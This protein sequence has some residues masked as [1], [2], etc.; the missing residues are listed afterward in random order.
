VLIGIKS[1]FH[2]GVQDI[3]DCKFCTWIRKRVCTDCDAK[4]NAFWDKSSDWEY[5]ETGYFELRDEESDA[6]RDLLDRADGPLRDNPETARAIYLDLAQGGSPTAMFHVGLCSANGSSVE[7]DDW[8]AMEWYRAGT[9]AGSWTAAMA[10]A[11]LL[12]Q[13][14]DFESCD[15]VLDDA[16][17]KGVVTAYYRM[18]RYKYGRAPNRR[19]AREIRSLLDYAI[20]NEHPGA[21]MFL[22][23]L[24]TRG[25]FGL[26]NIIGGIRL[27]V[28]CMNRYESEFSDTSDIDPTPAAL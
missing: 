21:E 4:I 9:I 15:E 24:M 26:R 5:W 10:Y 28:N 27:G 16:I 19:T 22:S 12:N 23:E 2:R 13:H 6:N 7:R 25:K 20:A 17:K 1:K 3:S 18:A 14:G 11:K 8:D